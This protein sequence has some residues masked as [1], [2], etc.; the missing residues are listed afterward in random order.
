MDVSLLVVK[1]MSDKERVAS[2]K[3]D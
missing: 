2:P 3:T 1:A